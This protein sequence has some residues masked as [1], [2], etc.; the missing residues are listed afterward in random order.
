[1]ATAEDYQYA[2]DLVDGIVAR[3]PWRAQMARQVGDPAGMRDALAQYLA[4]VIDTIEPEHRPVVVADIGRGPDWPD[5][6]NPGT[7]S[8]P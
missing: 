5:Y 6:C 4:D 3:D 2:A 7:D 8:G 1:M